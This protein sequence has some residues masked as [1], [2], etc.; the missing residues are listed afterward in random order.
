MN[1]YVVVEGETE[2]A[3]YASWIPF[4]NPSLQ[5]V[6]YP[7]NA[8]NNNYYIISGGG[9]PQYYDVIDDAILNVTQYNQ[10][11]RL[12]IAIDSDDMTR[13][14][15]YNEVDQ[16]IQSKRCT[17]NIKIIVQHFCFETWALANTLIVRKQP[18]TE[19]L[20]YYKSIYN[21]R[22]NDP[23]NLPPLKVK[24]LNRSQFAEVYLRAALNDKFH[25]L[26]YRKGDATIV[27]DRKYFGQ[28]KN[29]YSSM[30]HIASLSDFLSAF[31]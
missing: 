1:I 6:D 17:A 11:D 27:G 24:E 5:K 15:K 23:E 14:N 19:N 22:S 25:N 10:Y 20:R 28:V 18:R 26:T 2:K 13:Q 29:R 9:F 12:V 3:V 21:V 7:E 30:N 31:I 8:L 4:V 16:F